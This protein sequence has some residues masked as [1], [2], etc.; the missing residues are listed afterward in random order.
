MY[1]GSHKNVQEKS[2]IHKSTTEDEK[3]TQTNTL[4]QKQKK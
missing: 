1:K 4:L 3:Y 2:N